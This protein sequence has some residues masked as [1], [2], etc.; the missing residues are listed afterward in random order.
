MFKCAQ[1][2]RLCGFKIAGHDDVARANEKA[3]MQHIWHLAEARQQPLYPAQPLHMM[4][5]SKP[6]QPDG[7]D[8]P[9]A[10]RH[11]PMLQ[12]PDQHFMQV[13]PFKFK[14]LE[15]ADM[16]RQPQFRFG[17]FRQRDKIIRM[18]LAHQRDLAA[19]FQALPRILMNRFQHD[20]ARFAQGCF[21][22]LHQALIHQRR[23]TVE[24]IYRQIMP[25]YRFDRIQRTPTPEHRQPRKQRPFVV[26]QQVI[27]PRNRIVQRLLPQWGIP[28]AA[29]KNVQAAV[30]PVQQR[31]RGQQLAARRR[32]FNRQR[33][34]IQPGADLRYRWRIIRVQHKVRLRHLC[35]LDEQPP[36]FRFRHR[37]DRSGMYRWQ[38]QR[39]HRIFLLSGQ[40]QRLAAGDQHL[41]PS[42]RRQ[43][44]RYQRRG[45]HHML[46]IVDQQQ[47]VSPIAGP[48][49]RLCQRFMWVF[50]HIKRGGDG[51]RHQFSI[52]HRGQ[53]NKIH[54]IGKMIRQFCP[55]PQRQPGLTR[56]AHPRQRE[57]PR[58]L[59]Q[60]SDFG[61]FAAA[62]DKRGCLH[63]ERGPERSGR[64]RRN[65][66]VQQAQF[67]R[68]CNRLSPAAYPQLAVN[69]AVVPA[70]RVRAEE[71]ISSDLLV[72]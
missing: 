65:T 32:Q 24:H 29:C 3:G 64:R 36:R 21:L 23:Q 62:S 27:A 44:I 2:Q 12:R 37:F 5:V 40:A 39:R 10:C 52:M 68:P 13:V 34:A 42:R 72:R 55:H 45:L 19:V 53:I 70:D 67:I 54:P 66:R 71:Q 17:P 26:I 33:Q 9:H 51:F 18:A 58:C 35:P 49:Q 48:L 30:Q 4:A 6:V 43:Q 14:P 63:R 15:P 7:A 22:L 20:K 25:A 57:Q 31:L 8:Q 61:S 47:H 46:K 1:K 50:K 41:Q 28:G 38:S 60:A 56:A 59:Q 11:L 69:L 16:G